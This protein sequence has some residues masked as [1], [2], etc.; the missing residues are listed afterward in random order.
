MVAGNE[1]AHTAVSIVAVSSGSVVTL[2]VLIVSQPTVALTVSTMASRALRTCPMMVA[3]NE[4][5]HTAVSIVAVSSGS[6][7]TLIVL[8]VSQ[9]TVA[10]T[11]ST[12]EPG[13][14]KT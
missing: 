6:V 8:I 1:L 10:L 3:G 11:V 2:I 13:A 12:M 5:A 14:L 7:V 4:L 9:P